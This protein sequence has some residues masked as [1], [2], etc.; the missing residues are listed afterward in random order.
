[1]KMQLCTNVYMYACIVVV[2]LCMNVNASMYVW[3]VLY[4]CQLQRP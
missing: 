3:Y 2:K 4:V 1:M